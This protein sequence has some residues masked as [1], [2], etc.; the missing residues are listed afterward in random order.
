[1]SPSV[2]RIQPLGM[3]VGINGNTKVTW[4]TWL[5]NVAGCWSN[6]PPH[7]LERLS[8]AD[9]DEIRCR[10]Q[11]CATLALLHSVR[12]PDLSCPCL[13]AVLSRRVLDSS[14]EPYYRFCLRL[15]IR[16]DGDWLVASRLVRAISRFLGGASLG[17]YPTPSSNRYHGMENIGRLKRLIRVSISTC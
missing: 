13:Y 8:G 17:S 9:P 11:R 5:M 7:I 16:L 15:G 1:M 2:V 12:H 6:C 14:A 10:N 4:Y 3:I